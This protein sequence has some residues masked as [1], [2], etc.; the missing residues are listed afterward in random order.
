MNRKIAKA[1]LNPRIMA[2]AC[3]LVLASC[4]F[5]AP[6]PAPQPVDPPRSVF[7]VGRDPFYPNSTRV[8]KAQIVPVVVPVNIVKLSLNGLSGT[9]DKRLAIINNRTFEVGE[10][11]EMRV[12]GQPVKVKCIEIRDR[13]V[14]ITAN[15]VAQEMAMAN[16]F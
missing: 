11:A 12:N 14:V 2:A 13:T 16:K 9:K 5:A 4:A 15:G 7:T 8:P 6:T 3:G 1:E 10:E